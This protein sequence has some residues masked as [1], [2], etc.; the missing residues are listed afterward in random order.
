MKQSDLMTVARAELEKLPELKPPDWL[1]HVKT[2]LGKER[3][4]DNIADFWYSRCASLLFAL[5]H[6]ASGVQALRNKYGSKQK[7][8]RG[9]K[10][11]HKKAGGKII[12]TALQMLEKIG[13]VE[14]EKNGRVLTSK[15][16]SFIN[17]L[18]R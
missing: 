4:P 1:M 16:Q 12:R 3:R 10:F 18:K 15:G 14:K 8:T 7:H 17:K 11:H 6:G 9:G 13:F 2:G 5:S